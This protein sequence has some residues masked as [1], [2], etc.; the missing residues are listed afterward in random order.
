M[1]FSGRSRSP[2]LDCECETDGMFH[3]VHTRWAN[4]H[5]SMW[6]VRCPICKGAVWIREL[7]KHDWKTEVSYDLTNRIWFEHGT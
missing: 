6:C 7:K 2:Y 1:F 5:G 4:Q 3:S